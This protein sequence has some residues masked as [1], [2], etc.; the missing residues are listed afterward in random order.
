MKKAEDM[1]DSY[2]AGK[3]NEKNCLVYEGT[4]IVQVDNKKKMSIFEEYR[5]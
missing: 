3:F 1:E 2:V 5:K 4:T